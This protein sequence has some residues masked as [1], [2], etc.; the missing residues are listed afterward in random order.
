VGARPLKIPSKIANLK[1]SS[2][3]PHFKASTI[4][5][6]FSK[7]LKNTMFRGKKLGNSVLRNLN[8]KT[9]FQEKG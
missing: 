5:F 8:I 6:N 1:N 7:N 3:I 2:K 9:Y 4:L